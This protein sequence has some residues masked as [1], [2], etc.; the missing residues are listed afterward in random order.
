MINNAGA[1]QEFDAALQM[2]KSDP[3]GALGRFQ[4]IAAGSRP[5]KADAQTHVQ[6]IA[7]QFAGAEAQQQFNTAEQAQK[8][9]DLAGALAQFKALAAKPGPKQSDAQLRVQQI[10]DQMAAQAQQEVQ[11]QLDAAAQLE[12]SGD[13]K[14]AL[15]KYSAVAGKP[16][17]QQELAKLHAQLV[18]QKIADSNKP[19]TPPTP[20]PTPTSTSTGTARNP[21]VTVNPSGDCMPLTRPVQKGMLVPDYNVDGCPLKHTSLFDGPCC[22]RSTQYLCVDQNQ[23]R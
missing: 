6:Q 2:E 17:P 5:F 21:E 3:K 1:K 20:T 8:S 10:T 23:H 22:R 18:S 9:G 19:V 13:L 16:G 7:E 4:A 15:D 12:K 11:Q 14:G